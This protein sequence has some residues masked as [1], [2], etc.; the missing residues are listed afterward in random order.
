GIPLSVIECKRP[1]MK[2]P[3][4]QAISQHLRSQQEDGIRALYV[5]AQLLLSIACQEAAYG[6]N[7]TPEE[8]WSQWKEKFT[9]KEEESKYRQRLTELKNAPVAEEERE[10][11]FEGRFRYVRDH[12]D[13]LESVEIQPTV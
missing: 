2:E 8:F 12:F 11:V 6:T 9:S 13:D 10:K 7:A 1:D 4:K 5:Y 3:L